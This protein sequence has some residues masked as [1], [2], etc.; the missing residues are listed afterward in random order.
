[1]RR[2]NEG[3]LV[4][5]ATYF[6]LITPP[7][8]IVGAIAGRPWIGLLCGVACGATAVAWSLL[9]TYQYYL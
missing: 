8:A 7:G 6:L 1:M 5:S 2:A 3:L 9:L 4:D